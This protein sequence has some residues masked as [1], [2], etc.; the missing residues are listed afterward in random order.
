MDAKEK[1]SLIQKLLVL[2]K[3]V[4]EELKGDKVLDAISDIERKLRQIR[5]IRALLGETKDKDAGVDLKSPAEIPEGLVIQNRNRATPQSIEQMNKIAANPKFALLSGTNKFG[6]GTPVVAFGSIPDRNLGK[7]AEAVMPDG[8]NLRVRYAVMDAD[9]VLTSNTI[10]GTEVKE[11]FICDASKT[12]AIAG[13]GRVTALKKAYDIGTADAYWS[14]LLKHH[15]EYG[16]GAHLL[17]QIDKPILVR[18]MQPKD[19]TADIGDRSNQGQ[20][21]ELSPFEKANQDRKRIDTR[22]MDLDTEGMPTVEALNEFAKM[23]PIAEKGG[24]VDMKNNRPNRECE[25]RFMNACFMRAYDAGMSITEGNENAE[26]L[27][28]M[29]LL[30]IKL[31][32]ID[33]DD[34]AITG[35]LYLA[36]PTVQKLQGLSGGYDI[37]KC[38]VD[39][40][41]LCLNAKR[42]G[43]A[44]AAIVTQSGAASL[45]ARVLV[46]NKRSPEK[47]AKQLATIA[48]TVCEEAA[49]DTTGSFSSVDDVVKWALDEVRGKPSGAG[50]TLLDSVW[51]G[52]KGY[53]LL[54]S[55]LDGTYKPGDIS[56]CLESAASAVP[57]ADLPE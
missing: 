31:E 14:D 43:N 13:N 39:A 12:R 11:Y 40:A 4:E 47:S 45:I 26:L 51:S 53:R 17:A 36:A 57:Q 6:E 34:R 44:S 9:D 20:N 21:M 32:S 7:E 1:I 56:S 33:P 42:F 15:A 28:A 3:E 27:G 29:D 48:R 23:L 2:T 41:N 46:E 24:L 35:A 5:I 49:R 54:A 22:F 30:S 8:E 55:I 52:A 38:F 50:D 16:I 37:R 25:R 10:D 18:V 19:I